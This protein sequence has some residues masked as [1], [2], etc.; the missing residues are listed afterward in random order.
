MAM[1]PS[2]GIIA[3]KTYIIVRNEDKFVKIRCSEIYMG[4]ICQDGYSFKC[5]SLFCQLW[6][7]IVT[8]SQNEITKPMWFLVL[9]Y[10]LESEYISRNKFGTFLGALWGAKLELYLG[11]LPPSI[12]NSLLNITFSGSLNTLTCSHMNSHQGCY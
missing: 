3:W 8:I 5:V 9:T 7:L 10:Q 6:S 1:L 2:E 12:D 4:Q 11:N